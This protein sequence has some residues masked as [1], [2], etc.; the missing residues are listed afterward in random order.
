LPRSK[1]LPFKS[2]QVKF[3][4]V[5]KLPDTRLIFTLPVAHYTLY[6]KIF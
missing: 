5:V 4:V 3:I 1:S 6:K 2:S